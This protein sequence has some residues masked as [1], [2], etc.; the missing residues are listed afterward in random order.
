MKKENLNEE[1]IT[2]RKVDKIMLQKLLDL[3]KRTGK[4]LM[5]SKPNVSRLREIN[6]E[7]KGLVLSELYKKEI[8]LTATLRRK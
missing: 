6:T 1:K 2:M 3:S 7:L 8:S 4:I 5:S